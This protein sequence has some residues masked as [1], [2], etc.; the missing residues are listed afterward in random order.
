MNT[1]LLSGVISREE[2]ES[3]TCITYL[4]P[5]LSLSTS[6]SGDFTSSPLSPLLSPPLGPPL[7][8][9][10]TPGTSGTSR[11]SKWWCLVVLSAS[12]LRL[13]GSTKVADPGE[14]STDL[15]VA[16]DR[17]QEE[18]CATLWV[19]ET[20][21]TFLQSWQRRKPPPSESGPLRCALRRGYSLQ[22]GK[23]EDYSCLPLGEDS[24]CSQSDPAPTAGK[25]AV[26]GVLLD[27]TEFDTDSDET[28]RWL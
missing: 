22:G 23:V 20:S 4:R 13:V 1:W 15:G 10:G 3:Q 16:E 24:C 19:L 2:Q 28:A 5:A 12:R 11:T 17:W 8:P 14:D 27:L 9:F 7:S 26:G 18:W 25:P 6:V 21:Y